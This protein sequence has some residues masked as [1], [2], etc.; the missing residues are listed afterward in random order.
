MTKTKS[1]WK[2]Q[3]ERKLGFDEILLGQKLH[4]NKNERKHFLEILNELVKEYGEKWVRRNKSHLLAD[5]D[6]I[7]HEGTLRRPIY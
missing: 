3:K 5:V 6:F 2:E 4:G 1:K 7:L